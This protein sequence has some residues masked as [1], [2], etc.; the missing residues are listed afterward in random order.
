MDLKTFAVSQKLHRDQKLLYYVM[1][2]QT[3]PLAVIQDAFGPL[4]QTQ[5]DSK[6]E[7][8]IENYQQLLRDEIPI[9]VRRNADQGFEISGDIPDTL[10][11]AIEL[12]HEVSA[13]SAV[14]ELINTHMEQ[15]YGSSCEIL[16]SD[17][18]QEAERTL[19]AVSDIPAITP[20]PND[21]ATASVISDLTV[22]EETAVE[23]TSEM[24][25]EQVDMDGYDTNLFD[26][27]RDVLDESEAMD[28]S[29]EQT[30][31][32]LEEAEQKR[33]TQAIKRIYEKLVADIHAYGLDR[34]LNL[35][36]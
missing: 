15:L 28:V 13:E 26:H 36:L 30:E 23:P 29:E 21:S 2:E 12:V 32:E 31:Q 27:G 20:V 7:R 6:A 3:V 25:E 14:Q 19:L 22:V 5:S 18:T 11:E 4:L 9:L 16:H 17:L 24:E 10:L 34:Q 35:Q 1:N 33:F 8:L